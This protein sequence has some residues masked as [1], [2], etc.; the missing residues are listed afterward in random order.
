MIAAAVFVTLMWLAVVLLGLSAWLKS[1]RLLL[2]A[3]LTALAFA[4]VPVGYGIYMMW[5]LVVA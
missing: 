2:A 1:R 5:T 4:L 3:G